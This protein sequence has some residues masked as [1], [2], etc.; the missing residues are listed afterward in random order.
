MNDIVKCLFL[1]KFEEAVR[2]VGG[3]FDADDLNRTSVPIG[4]WDA[5]LTMLCLKLGND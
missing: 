1:P 3:T 2:S 4:R 5:S